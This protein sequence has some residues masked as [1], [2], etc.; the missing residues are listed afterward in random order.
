MNGNYYALFL[1]TRGSRPVL[2][3]VVVAIVVAT[4]SRRSM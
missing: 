1:E 4:T 3:E 2:V